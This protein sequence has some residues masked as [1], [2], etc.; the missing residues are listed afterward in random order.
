M[1]VNLKK[2]FD[3]DIGS[4]VYSMFLRAIS[5][6]GMAD[7]ISRGVLVG[8]SGGADSV[9]LLCALVKYTRDNSL[10]LPIAVHLNHMIRGAEADRDESFS[11][12]FS[13]ALGIEFLSFKRDIPSEAKR[14]S[15]GVEETARN[16]RYSIF[17]DIIQGRND[18]SCIAVAHNSTDNLETVIF[19]MM[20]GAGARGASGIAPVRGRIIRPIIYSPKRDILSALDLANVPFVTDSTNFE[21]EYK[22][23]YI[24]S[25]ILPKLFELSDDPEAQAVKLS[26]ALRSDSSYIE[27]VAADFVDGYSNKLIPADDLLVLHDAVFSRVVS[28]MAKRSGSSGI[29]YTHTGKLRRLISGGNRNFSLSLP[30][31]VSFLCE[32]GLCS[33]TDKDVFMTPKYRYKLSLGEN[34]IK[35]IDAL[36][37]VSHEPIE[38]SSKVYKIAIQ[39]TIDFDIIEGEL[40]IR[41]KRDGD[42]YVYGGMTRKLKKLFNDKSFTQYERAH[43]AVLCDEKGILWVPGFKVRDGGSKNPERKLYVAVAYK[44]NF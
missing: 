7:K 2:L 34:E 40:S 19:N 5:D 43:T 6:F 36:V 8:F 29:E 12:E 41:E 28:L 3:S 25:E 27:S 15:K 13:G 22:R 30:G 18:I 10:K 24:R 16:V 23:N 26:H 44:T 42:S 31:G 9:M 35:E 4:K 21:T 32:H 33:V 11:R 37:L 39:Q 38:Y 17:D 14:L 20:R 1:D